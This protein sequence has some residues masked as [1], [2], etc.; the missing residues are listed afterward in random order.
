VPQHDQL[1]RDGH[2]LLGPLYVQLV[3]PFTQTHTSAAAP[4]HDVLYDCYAGSQGCYPGRK[5]LPAL[6]L[7][8]N[9]HL[10]SLTINLHTLT[11]PVQG[12][13]T[14]LVMGLVLMPGPVLDT[15]Q[16][17]LSALQTIRHPQ[18]AG[19]RQQPT[20]P[21]SS[22][23]QNLLLLALLPHAG[24]LLRVTAPNLTYNGHA[25]ALQ[26]PL[27]QPLSPASH[28]AVPYW[29][30]S[31]HQADRPLQQQQQQLLCQ[32][33]AAKDAAGHWHVQRAALAAAVAVLHKHHQQCTCANSAV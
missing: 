17:H 9:S 23:Y 8:I 31:S 13:C 2:R 29:G 18:A 14:D 33:T 15:Q 4:H 28:T 3:I 27:F 16:F 5:V 22:S 12:L 21:S 19:S 24:W 10:V 11:Q 32:T 26:H 1:C 7:Q 25:P 20:S 6:R 30:T